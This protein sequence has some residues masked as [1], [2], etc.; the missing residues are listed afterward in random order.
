L[1]QHDNDEYEGSNIDANS[2]YFWRQIISKAAEPLNKG[3]R[4]QRRKFY[5]GLP[6][7]F[8]AVVS[9]ERRIEGDGTY[10]YPANYPAH[11]S[12]AGVVHAQANSP[13]LDFMARV[14]S[15]EWSLYVKRGQIKPVPR[16]SVYSVTSARTEFAMLIS[17]HQDEFME[18]ATRFISGCDSSSSASQ[19]STSG[20]T[21]G[22]QAAFQQHTPH[23]TA[24]AIQRSQINSSTRCHTCGGLGHVS[25][26]DGNSCLTRELGISIPK[27]T[28]L[29]IKYPTGEPMSP[30]LKEALMAELPESTWRDA[31]VYMAESNPSS[32]DI[33]KLALGSEAE[34]DAA[35]AVGYRSD[36]GR[37]RGKGKQPFVRRRFPGKG[38]GKPA[39]TNQQVDLAQNCED[40]DAQPSNFYGN[41]ADEPE[42]DGEVVFHRIRQHRRFQQYTNR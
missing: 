29:Q 20:D 2:L 16:G 27:P 8:D 32:L 15:L 3:L 42:H 41:C 40:Y 28:L 12:R 11:H 6:E 33:A 23:A 5:V 25:S 38:K 22:D 26:I 19:A 39:L 31:L 30:Q 1:E 18:T 7:S 9:N 13:D 21:P 10:V 14:F 37:G 34:Y 17:A 36:G 24:L 35:Q 4:Q